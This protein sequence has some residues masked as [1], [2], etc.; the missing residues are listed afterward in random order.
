MQEKKETIK[1]LFQISLILTFWTI[2]PCNNTQIVTLLDRLSPKAMNSGVWADGSLIYLLCFLFTILT[3][4]LIYG[5]RKRL[6]IEKTISRKDLKTTGIVIAI[7]ISLISI[8]LIPSGYNFE[9]RYL[10]S[11]FIVNSL[12]VAIVEEVTFRRILITSISQ[13]SSRPIL[14]IAVS[15]VLFTIPHIVNYI[16]SFSNIH[17]INTIILLVKVAYLLILGIILAFIYIQQKN[18][19]TCI[20][21][22]CGQNI[23]AQL[24]Y[25]DERKGL[26]LHFLAVVLVCMSIFI[27]QVKERRR[28][29]EISIKKV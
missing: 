1:G 29:Y 28:T 11:V 18:I 25:I 19:L 20:I 5:R 26:L 16:E 7:Y 2:I 24:L 9:I 22:H 8:L 6:F 10:F 23:L 12:M 13:F 17:D 14:I 3:F 21:I 15:A 4:F 27:Q